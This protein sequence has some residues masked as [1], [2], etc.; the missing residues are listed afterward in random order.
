MSE[1]SQFTLRLSEM[2]VRVRKEPSLKLKG[3]STVLSDFSI[4][5]AVLK[6]RRRRLGNSLRL[7]CYVLDFYLLIK[8]TGLQLKQDL[9]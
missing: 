3:R 5:L 6:Q 7:R 2:F 9:K 8:P 4:E 1:G